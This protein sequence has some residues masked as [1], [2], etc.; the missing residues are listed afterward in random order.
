MVRF[1]VSPVLFGKIP[2]EVK[3]EVGEVVA[4][5]VVLMVALGVSRTSIMGVSLTNEWKE[6]YPVSWT[7]RSQ[8]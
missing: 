6:R 4:V 2:G 3:G 1:H 5:D 7:R 8:S